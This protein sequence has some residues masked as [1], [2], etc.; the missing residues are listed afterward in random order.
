MYAPMTSNNN[1]DMALFSRPRIQVTL[2]KITIECG[3]LPLQMAVVGPGHCL[4]V[5]QQMHSQGAALCCTLHA[6]DSCWL[7]WDREPPHEYDVAAD[8]QS[9]QQRC[10]QA[11]PA[12]TTI[13][14]AP[15]VREVGDEN[16][17]C[18]HWNCQI[19]NSW[20]TELRL[21]IPLDSWHKTGHFTLA[22]PPKSTVTWMYET[23]NHL[24][25]LKVL[26][27]PVETLRYVVHYTNVRL[28][29]SAKVT[30]CEVCCEHDSFFQ[31]RLVV[32]DERR[33]PLGSRVDEDRLI[34][35]TVSCCQQV[36]DTAWI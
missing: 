20:V 18:Y 3:S 6:D 21:Y 22:F 36:T 23:N 26:Q 27:N 2:P 32:V 1:T 14:P 9:R 16:S 19:P 15:S 29:C 30:R 13:I 12:M 7:Q 24:P 25:V 34:A 28:S 4:Q 11:S 31:R 5:S 10:P 33:W 8:G 17:T 35:G